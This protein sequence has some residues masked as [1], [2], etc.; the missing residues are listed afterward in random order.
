MPFFDDLDEN[1]LQ[2]VTTNLAGL[3][4][5]TKELCIEIRPQAVHNH[6][7]VRVED[8]MYGLRFCRHISH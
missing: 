6:M 7:R 5:S 2:R 3:F 8:Q 4:W 1:M